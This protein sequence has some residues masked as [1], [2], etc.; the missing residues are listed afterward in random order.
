VETERS[1]ERPLVGPEVG[2]L[3]TS[4]VGPKVVGVH[5]TLGAE[6]GSVCDS[7]AGRLEGDSLE[8]IRGAVV[9]ERSDR[10]FSD[11]VIPYNEGLIV[12]FQ[13]LFAGPPPPP[14]PFLLYRTAP[15]L[16]EVVVVKAAM[17]TRATVIWVAIEIPVATVAAVAIVSAPVAAD[18][19]VDA[20]A[21]TAIC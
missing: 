19:P 10:V 13:V 21:W 17:A 15:T 7:P 1:F 5:P 16:T 3:A 9:G 20:A 18:V 8:R 12:G 6:L 4:A 14:P 2:S 11:E